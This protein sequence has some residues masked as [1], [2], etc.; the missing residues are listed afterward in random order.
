MK[1]IN[2]IVV[3][4]FGIALLIISYQLDA[5]T[6]SFFSSMEFP[7]LDV[8]FSS[9]TNFGI[10]FIVM[11]VIPSIIFYKKNRKIAYLLWAAFLTSLAF[12]L[13]IKFMFLR[14]RPTDPF[15]FPFTTIVNYSF[16]SMHAM[17]VFALLPILAKYLSRQ[18]YFWIG[19]GLLAVLSRI[20]LGFHFLSDVVFGAFAGYFI[21]SLMLKLYGRKK[22]WH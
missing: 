17:A 14:Q 8:I 13:A 1:K 16:P 7:A 5:K 10:V 3:L 21:G 22:S 12:A 2:D 19:F 4:I 9:I 6:N 20:Y 11:V 15:M 18:K